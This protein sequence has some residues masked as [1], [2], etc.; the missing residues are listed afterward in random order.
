MG[1]FGLVWK[2]LVPSLWLALA[3][4]WLAAPPII[5]WQLYCWFFLIPE[6]DDSFYI[7]LITA[8]TGG[9]FIWGTICLKKSFSKL[10][11]KRQTNLSDSQHKTFNIVMGLLLIIILLWVG[12]RT[13][14]WPIVWFDQIVYIRH[15]QGFATAHNINHF[16]RGYDLQIGSLWVS[17]SQSVRPGLPMIYA[18][19]FLF[20]SGGQVSEGQI[21]S[22]AFY[23]LLGLMFLTGGL[24][25]R[26]FKKIWMALTAIFL[27]ISCYYFTAFSI[28]GFKELIIIT[29]ILLGI[30]VWN[31]P[32]IKKTNIE[33]W[34]WVGFILALA[35]WIN[36]TGSILA[37]IILLGWLLSRKINFQG[38]AVITGTVILLS[39]LEPLFLV[40]M[41]TESVLSGAPDRITIERNK[42]ATTE[43]AKNE[44]REYKINNDLDSWIK[45]RLQGLTQIQY[46]GLFYWLTLAVIFSQRKQII[47]DPLLKEL[48]L[49]LGIYFFLLT[50]PLGL[51]QSR[52]AHVLIISPKYVLIPV[53]LAAILVAGGMAPGSCG[54]ARPGS[55]G[56]Q[57]LR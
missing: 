26:K 6:K 20:S 3:S 54:T 2:N 30:A 34:L 53:P 43:A 57:S 13:I 35:A 1:V 49:V 42:L 44:L 52:L 37:G 27:I 4:S 11:R 28:W 38:M 46:F 23:Y 45:G 55:R 7:K 18:S 14:L 50:D 22:L 33:I 32:G 40:K 24:M 19:M 36:F 16:L 47:R 51:N 39:G 41:A 21:Q 15:G 48:V 31:E 25:I 29:L 5:A 10:T 12:I 8:V 9:I 17:Y 56:R